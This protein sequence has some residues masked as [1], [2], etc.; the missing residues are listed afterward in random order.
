MIELRRSGLNYEYVKRLPVEYEGVLLGQQ[1]ARLILVEGKVLLA[2][3]ALREAEDSIAEQLKARMR[4][5]GVDLG[6]FANFYGTR[7]TIASV[8]LI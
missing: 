5:L 2:A 7:L 3:F 8:R 4:R 1:D 6:L